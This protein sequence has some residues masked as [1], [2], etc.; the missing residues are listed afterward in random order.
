[1]KPTHE[2]NILRKIVDFLLHNKQL[3]SY[4]PSISDKG[5]AIAQRMDELK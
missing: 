1:M 3:F 4:A 5:I 2:M